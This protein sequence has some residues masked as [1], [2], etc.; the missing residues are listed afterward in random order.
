MCEELTKAVKVIDKFEAYTFRHRLLHKHGSFGPD[1]AYRAKIVLTYAERYRVLKTEQVDRIVRIAFEPKYGEEIKPIGSG[2][3]E[4]L[5]FYTET[6]ATC[7][8]SH[9]DDINR[10]FLNQE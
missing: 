7:F 9:L 5:S 2:Y 1:K 3:D 8:L 10:F 6:D 4:I